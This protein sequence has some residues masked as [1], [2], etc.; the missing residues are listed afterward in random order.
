MLSFHVMSCSDEKTFNTFWWFVFKHTCNAKYILETWL[1]SLIN[2]LSHRPIGNESV[3]ANK[4]FMS[5][6]LNSTFVCKWVPKEPGPSDL[7]IFTYDTGA[8][9]DHKQDAWQAEEADNMFVS[10]NWVTSKCKRSQ[11]FLRGGGIAPSW[12]RTEEF[13]EMHSC[14]IFSELC[15]TQCV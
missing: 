15:T 10:E 3:L 5:L 4:I 11:W 1:Q 12:S 13:W 6:V 2:S 14:P 7:L 8:C 9:G